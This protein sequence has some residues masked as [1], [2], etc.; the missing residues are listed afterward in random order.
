MIDNVLSTYALFEMKLL[1]SVMK[2]SRRTNPGKLVRFVRYVDKP[3][4]KRDGTYL[5]IGTMIEAPHANI[6]QDA[7]PYSNHTEA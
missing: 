2:E 3:V 6:V 5:P 7:Q 4:T 1:D